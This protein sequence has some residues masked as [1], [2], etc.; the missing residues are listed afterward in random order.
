M[1]VSPL[2][3]LNELPMLREG[4]LGGGGALLT[5]EIPDSCG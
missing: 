5:T 1:Q 2:A 4:H 3:N